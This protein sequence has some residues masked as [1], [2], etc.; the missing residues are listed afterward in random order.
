MTEQRG[1]HTGY[2]ETQATE[3]LTHSSLSNKD[4]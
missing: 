4:L 2:T 1:T 3:Q